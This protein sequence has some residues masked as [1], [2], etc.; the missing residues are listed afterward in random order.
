MKPIR[1]LCWTVAALVVAWFV[2]ATPARATFHLWQVAEVYSNADGT[3]QYI[4]FATT[5]AG[6]GVLG[7]HVIRATSDGVQRNFTI[8]AGL[9]GSTQNKRFLVATPGFANLPGAVTPDYVLPCGPFF[10][11]DAASIRVELIG[12]DSLTFAGSALPTDGANALFSTAADVLSTGANAPTNFA[13]GNG[14]LALTPCQIAGTCEPCDDGLYCNGAE[15]CANSACVATSP[16]GSLCDEEGDRCVEC[17]LPADC[18]DANVC[19]SESCEDGTCVL[20]DV[21]NNCDDGQF[22]TTF[23]MCASGTCAGGTM[24]PCGGENCNED[25][26]YCGECQFA[27]D[28]EDGDPCTTHSCDAGR[29]SI[30][31]AEDGTPCADNG[32]FCDGAE[33]CFVG[34]CQSAGAACNPELQT[35]NEDDDVCVPIPESGAAG[36]V[37]A[38]LALAAIARSSTLRRAPR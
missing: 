30:G 3:I 38:L 18:D 8:P 27:S 36:G 14:S 12:A 37:A 1:T 28:C 31:E 6:Q 13:G 15:G 22:C 33:I 11:P 24:G 21:P 26:D 10:A 16:C 34:S 25:G 17:F 2:T 19:T 9:T 7:A 35:C 29:C 4:E 5:F 32:I 23:D 20:T